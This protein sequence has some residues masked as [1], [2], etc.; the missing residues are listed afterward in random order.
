[1][2]LRNSDLYELVRGY[3][4]M[5]GIKLPFKLSYMMA[6][7]NRLAQTEIKD[8]ETGLPPSEEFQA[9]E[10]S[11][12]AI[13]EKFA[14]R[15]EDGQFE[16]R[17]RGNRQEYV[18]TDESR[19]EFETAMSAFSEEN[20][21][22]YE[23]RDAAIKAWEASLKEPVSADVADRLMTIDAKIVEDE[24]VKEKFAVEPSL[25]EPWLPFIV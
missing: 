12:V 13:V 16:L 14:K 9:I 10:R 20:K 6:K 1:M 15:G 17:Q 8:L 4:K 18:I 25:L 7:N 3:E 2:E 23:K 5:K 21:D 24:S 22:A 11:R 19:A